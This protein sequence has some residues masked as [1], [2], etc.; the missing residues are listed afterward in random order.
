[1]D[2]RESADWSRKARR[3]KKGKE[4]K[5]EEQ[6]NTRDREWVLHAACEWKRKGESN[7]ERGKEEESDGGLMVYELA[8][9]VEKED[10]MWNESRSKVLGVV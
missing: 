6:A 3:E 2:K 10:R 8:V 1:M 7:V 4:G 9:M 5:K